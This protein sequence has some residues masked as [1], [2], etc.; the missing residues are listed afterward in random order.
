MD[1]DKAAAILAIATTAAQ[2][3]SATALALHRRGALHPNES[4]QLA[5]MARHLGELFQDAGHDDMASDFG[6]HAALLRKPPERPGG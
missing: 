5:M 2:L 6:A 4:E 1:D 3:A